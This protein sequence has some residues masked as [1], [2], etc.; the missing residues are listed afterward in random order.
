MW[1][2]T[3]SYLD[4][5]SGESIKEEKRA[6]RAQRDQQERERKVKDWEGREKAKL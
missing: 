4:D 1:R 5:T 2:E 3:I 6:L